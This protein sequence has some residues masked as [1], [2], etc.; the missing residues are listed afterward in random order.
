[1]GAVAPA[2]VVAPAEPAVVGPVVPVRAAALVLEARAL[3]LAPQAERAQV[4][5]REAAPVAA[6]RVGGPVVRLAPDRLVRAQAR[7][8]AV[9]PAARRDR[10]WAPPLLVPDRAA[11]LGPEAATTAPGSEATAWPAPDRVRRPLRRPRPGRR[12]SL[13]SLGLRLS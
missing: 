3:G 12:G 8:A 10:G 4:E 7:P 11:P 5:A 13:G 9:R 6:P 1:V 2:V